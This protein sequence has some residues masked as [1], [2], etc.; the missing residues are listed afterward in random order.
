[1]IR[2]TAATLL[3]LILVACASTPKEPQMTVADIT[4]KGAKRLT[5]PEVRT[6]MSGAKMEGNAWTSGAA[7]TSTMNPNGT[8]DG[9]TSHGRKFDG[10]WTVNEADGQAC[11]YIRNAPPAGSPCAFTY[12]LNGTYYISD[13]GQP[14][15]R[16]VER[17]FSR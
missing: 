10:T 17:R 14:G 9:V 7:F 2:A 1:M 5:A 11:T 12:G 16:V 13:T 4:A 3:S 6:L 15:G 8:F